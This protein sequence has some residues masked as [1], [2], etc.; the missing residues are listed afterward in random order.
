MHVQTVLTD[1]S[2]RGPDHNCTICGKCFY[3]LLNSSFLGKKVFLRKSIE[4]H[5]PQHLEAVQ[6]LFSPQLFN[7]IQKT[8][9]KESRDYAFYMRDYKG[10]TMN[11]I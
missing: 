3:F 6:Q 2:S 10:E 9:K 7:F 4:N 1:T 11:L 5:L 8:F